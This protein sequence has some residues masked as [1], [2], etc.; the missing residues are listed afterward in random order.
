VK[1]ICGTTTIPEHEG[2]WTHSKKTWVLNRQWP[3]EEEVWA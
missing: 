1:H 2:S 3:K